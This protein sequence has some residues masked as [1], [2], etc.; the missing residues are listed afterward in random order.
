M[1]FNILNSAC[2]KLHLRPVSGRSVVTVTLY[3][4]LEHTAGVFGHAQLK[5][6]VRCKCSLMHQQVKSI[7]LL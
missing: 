6:N 7:L 1:C 5:H 4:S 2:G 3:D